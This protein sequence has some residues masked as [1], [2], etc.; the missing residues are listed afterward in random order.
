MAEV[1]EMV[2]MIEVGYL[3]EMAASFLVGWRR[4]RGCCWVV[5]GSGVSEEVAR[6]VVEGV[7]RRDVFILRS[8]TVGVDW[9]KGW[10]RCIE[11]GIC[12]TGRVGRSVSAAMG[13]TRGVGDGKVLVGSV[14]VDM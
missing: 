3:G 9:R 7:V 2:M 12:G 13:M 10:G 1:G 14:M 6:L 4:L 8:V 11:G 5:G